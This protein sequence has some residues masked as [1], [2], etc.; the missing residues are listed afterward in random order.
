MMRVNPNITLIGDRT[1]G[2]GGTPAFLELPTGWMY[3]FSRLNFAAFDR[4]F[5]KKSLY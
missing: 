4:V 5:F 2:G 3:R 1:G